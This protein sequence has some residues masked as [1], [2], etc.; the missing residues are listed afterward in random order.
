MVV[1]RRAGSVLALLLVA[2]VPAPAGSAQIQS[3]GEGLELFIRN[4][5]I[6]PDANGVFHV[7]GR[8]L[9]QFQVI[10]DRA[11]LIEAFGL[12]FGADT[13]VGEEVCDLPPQA[14][15]TGVY[16]PLEGYAVDLDKSDGFFIAINSNGDTSPQAEIGVAV[17]GYD[18]N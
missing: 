10:G 1:L 12:S 14:W 13:P 5:D 16:G 3:C 17:H 2:L 7:S 6:V 8:L 15:A 18:A 9:V 4:P 11:D